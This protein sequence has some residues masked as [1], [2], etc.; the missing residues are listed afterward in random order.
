M[1]DSYEKKVF[2]APYAGVQTSNVGGQESSMKLPTSAMR[3]GRIDL[4]KVSEEDLAD[5][6]AFEVRLEFR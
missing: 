3:T 4:G 1:N 5:V 2:I 6:S